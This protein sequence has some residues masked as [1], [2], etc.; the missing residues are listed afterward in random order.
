MRFHQTLYVSGLPS[1]LLGFV[2]VL[3]DLPALGVERNHWDGIPNPAIHRSS[4]DCCAK[5]MGICSI[6]GGACSR[7]ILR[8]SKSFA[9]SMLR[10]MDRWPDLQLLCYPQA[11]WNTRYTRRIEARR[12]RTWPCAKGTHLFCLLPK[13]YRQ[14]TCWVSPWWWR[15]RRRG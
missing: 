3:V 10:G 12:I 9:S 15:S 2:D 14:T 11:L 13:R 8:I 6:H 7:A 4:M 1:V 5:R